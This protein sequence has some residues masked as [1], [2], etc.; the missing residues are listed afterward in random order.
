MHPV[1]A[2][3]FPFTVIAAEETV[4]GAKSLPVFTTI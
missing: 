3:L 4:G 1:H 2:P